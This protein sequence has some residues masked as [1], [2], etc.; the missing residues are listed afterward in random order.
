MEFL[1]I[2]IRRREQMNLYEYEKASAQRRRELHHEMEEIRLGRSAARNHSSPMLGR[3]IIGNVGKSLVSLG[4]KLERVDPRNDLV[5]P[6]GR[7]VPL[8][9]ELYH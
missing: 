1:Q 7:R 9:G 4:E 3:R 6:V 5:S 2:G 8:S